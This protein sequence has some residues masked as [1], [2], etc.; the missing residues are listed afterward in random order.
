LGETL[1]KEIDGGKVKREDVF[2]TSKLWCTQHHEVEDAC[3]T[4]L[5][6]RTFILTCTGLELKVL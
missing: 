6:V 5:T 4:S 1:G 3:K 2:I